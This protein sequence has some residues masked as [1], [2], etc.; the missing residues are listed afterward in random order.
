MIFKINLTF[1]HFVGSAVVSGPSGAI[2]APGALAHGI[3]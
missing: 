1:D 2:V 3:W